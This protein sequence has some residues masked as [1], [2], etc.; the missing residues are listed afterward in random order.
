MLQEARYRT[1]IKSFTTPPRN[2]AILSDMLTAAEPA[3]M[4]IAPLMSDGYFRLFA[5]L[6]RPSIRRRLAL[7]ARVLR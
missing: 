6:K 3:L 2:D 4:P 5:H 7:L 1:P